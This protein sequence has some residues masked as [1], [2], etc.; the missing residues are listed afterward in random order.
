MS[1]KDYNRLTGCRYDDCKHCDLC[2]DGKCKIGI[3][4]NCKESCEA[5]SEA[6]K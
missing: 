1:H 2:V 5:E 3:I 6:D 4:E